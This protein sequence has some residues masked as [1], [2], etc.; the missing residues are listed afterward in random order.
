MPITMT[1]RSR[2]ETADRDDIHP[3]GASV[4]VFGSGYDHLER[5][6]TYAVA[7]ILL[8][9]PPDLLLEFVQAPPALFD[10]TRSEFELDEC[11]SPVI[12][13]KDGI[14]LQAVPVVIIRQFST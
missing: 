13:M 5:R 3:V 12:E 4:T 9:G 11:V 7:G 6:E 14:G 8:V 2:S 1:R 10:K